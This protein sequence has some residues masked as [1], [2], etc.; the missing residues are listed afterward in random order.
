MECL[1]IVTGRTFQPGLDV[2]P[3]EECVQRV[4]STTVVVKLF[5]NQLGIHG[6]LHRDGTIVLFRQGDFAESGQEFV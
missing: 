2:L 6:L 4:E 5:Q 1:R 3:G